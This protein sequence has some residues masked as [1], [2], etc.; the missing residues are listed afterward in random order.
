[1]PVLVV[2]EKAHEEEHAL[3]MRTRRCHWCAWLSAA[4]KAF[5]GIANLQM[6]MGSTTDGMNE[7]IVQRRIISELKNQ[8]VHWTVE[9]FWVQAETGV[10]NKVPPSEAKPD[11][12]EKDK[13]KAS[14]WPRRTGRHRNCVYIYINGLYIPGKPNGLRFFPRDWELV[15]SF[16]FSY[17]LPFVLQKYYII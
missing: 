11:L 9:W 5:Q 10:L 13:V 2:H 16:W 4:L 6:I 17:R 3:G 8:M 15:C 14:R 12:H 7:S 1:M